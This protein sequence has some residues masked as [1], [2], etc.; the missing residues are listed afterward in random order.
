MLGF[1]FNA[2]RWAG[3]LSDLCVKNRKC[4]DLGHCERLDPTLLRGGNATIVVEQAGLLGEL[5]ELAATLDQ[6]CRCVEFSHSP[7]VQNDDPI[8]VND[9]VNA[10]RNRD[11][12]PVRENAAA[13]G[14]LQQRIRLHINCSLSPWLAENCHFKSKDRT[15][16]RLPRLEQGYC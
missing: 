6:L 10:M 3:W 11:D 1:R 13:Q 8:G 15:I 7:L 12:S 2:L 9:R 4:G 16:L 5:V 14:T